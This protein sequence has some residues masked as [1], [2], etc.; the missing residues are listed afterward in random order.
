MCSLFDKRDALVT[1]PRPEGFEDVAIGLTS[2]RLV[3]GEGVALIERHDGR[4]DG[5]RYGPTCADLDLRF[6]APLRS[7]Q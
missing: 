2:D 7:A 3:F 4:V 6:G 5:A 1:M